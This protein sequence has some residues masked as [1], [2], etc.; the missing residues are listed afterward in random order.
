MYWIGWFLSYIISRFYVGVKVRGRRNIPKG[1]AFILAANHAS[2]ADPFILGTSFCRPIE[3]L[4]K[5]E[6]FNHP[7]SRWIFTSFH[8]HPVRRGNGDYR[9]M[10]ETFKILQGGKPLL[11]FPEGTRSKNGR[12]QPGKPGV[13]FIVNKL[14]VPVVPVYIEGSYD[15]MPEDIKTLRRRP[16]KVYIGSPMRFDGLSKG[17]RGKEVYQEISDRI[18]DKISSLKSEYE[19]KVS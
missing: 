19:G 17:V 12:L 18:M 10:K 2:N 16:V 7:F 6:L 14:N 3:Y 9:A 15:A 5:E 13:G 8:A 11:I 1:G 4:A